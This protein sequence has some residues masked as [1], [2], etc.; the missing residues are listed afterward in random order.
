MLGMSGKEIWQMTKD[1]FSEWSE[2]R[3]SRL[4]AS[5]AYYTI[6]SMAPILIIVITIAGFIYGDAAAEGRIVAEIS[7]HVG[8]EAAATIETAIQNAAETGTGPIALTIGIIVLAVTATGVFVELQDALNTVWGVR[9]RPDRPWYAMIWDRVISF[10]M[11]LV[12]GF[13]LMVSFV[14]DAILAGLINYIGDF[15]PGAGWLSMIASFVLSL[16]VF[17]LVFAAIF[18][19]LPDAKVVWSDVWIG[20]IATAVLFAIGKFLIGLYLG[21]AGP[22]SVYGAAGSLIVILLWVYYSAQILFLGAEFTQVY[23]NRHGSRVRAGGKAVPMTPGARAQE[24][25]PTT[26]QQL[27]AQEEQ[28]RAKRKGQPAPLPLRDD[29][30][31]VD[32]RYAAAGGKTG[33][34]TSSNGNDHRGSTY[35]PY[36]TPWITLALGTLT[37]YFLTRKKPKPATRYS[38]TGHALRLAVPIDR[39]G[40]PDIQRLADSMAELEAGVPAEPPPRR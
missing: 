24:G 34:S 10:G 12:I 2:D 8:E 7:E 23:A 6:F 28:D 13:I 16:A 38:P 32:Q 21:R 3:V 18:K 30:A 1:T 35:T 25:I 4:S 36:Y 40:Q 15:F 39:K 5:V 9:P 19:I 14:A 20:A 33:S 31:D 29:E 26:K 11:I 37:G 27:R 22:G 17:T